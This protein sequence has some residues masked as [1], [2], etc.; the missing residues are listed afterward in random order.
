V[1]VVSMDAQ[2]VSWILVHFHGWVTPLARRGTWGRMWHGTWRRYQCA[3]QQ[4][5]CSPQGMQQP[6]ASVR[7]TVGSGL[8]SAGGV[9]GHAG[10]YGLV[11]SAGEWPLTSSRWQQALCRH[12]VHAAPPGGLPP[13]S[14]FLRVRHTVRVGLATTPMARMTPR[15]GMTYCSSTFSE[16]DAMAAARERRQQAAAVGP[17]VAARRSKAV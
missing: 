9:E 10:F 14:D 5:A 3:A 15:M 17:C 11:L 4:P 12:A 7:T 2:L 13:M 16:A 8:K 6:G 1:K